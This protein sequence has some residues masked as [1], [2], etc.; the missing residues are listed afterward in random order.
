MM[1]K[2]GA[3]VMIA[4]VVL[5]G[6]SG[7]PSSSDRTPTTSVGEETQPQSTESGETETESPS[8]TL[9]T[10]TQISSTETT[11]T[12]ATTTTAGAEPTDAPVDGSN[13]TVT[14]YDVMDGGDVIIVAFGNGSQ[15]SVKLH[16]V[17]A[18]ETS[19]SEITPDAFDMPAT[20]QAR[21]WLYRWG[22]NARE[23][24]EEQLDDEQVKI[25]VHGHTA[26]G[27]PTVSLYYGNAQTTLYNTKLLENGYARATDTAHPLSDE[28]IDTE[29]AAR[30]DTNGLWSFNESQDDLSHR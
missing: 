19:T 6:C 22:H 10:E 8:K 4:L 11:A 15:R 3:V 25:V 5:A 9:S 2:I 30:E 27:T 24:G 13:H 20:D 29:T 21:N 18:P 26:T 1:K 14:V 28:F 23:Y 12:T 16:G 17:E 7:T